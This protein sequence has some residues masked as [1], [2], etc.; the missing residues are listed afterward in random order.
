MT[1]WFAVLEL[2]FLLLATTFGFLT[3]RALKSSVLGRGM[4]FIAL[5]SLVMAV[6][7]VIM[8]ADQLLK[9]HILAALLGDVGGSWAWLVA[10]CT[11]WL[12]YGLGF[13]GLYK[14]LP[15]REAELRLVTRNY[16]R[17]EEAFRHSE[18]LYRSLVESVRDVIYTLSPDGRFSSSNPAFELYTGWSCSEWIGQPFVPLVHPEDLPLAMERFRQVLAG[19]SLPSYTLR[20]REKTGGYRVGEFI[21]TAQLRDGRTVGIL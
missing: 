11:S 15:M 6:G 4:T 3:A 2:P 8:I 1:T 13:T 7:H 20:I 12:F 16:E 21:Q 5:G 19:K 14:A 10:L 9:E 17:A 18:D